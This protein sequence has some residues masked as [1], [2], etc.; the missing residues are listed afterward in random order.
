MEAAMSSQLQR[1]LTAETV[2]ASKLLHGSK[3]DEQIVRILCSASTI[4]GHGFS[5]VEAVP[6]S[7]ARLV[8]QRSTLAAVAPQPARNPPLVRPGVVIP[9]SWNFGRRPFWRLHGR[10]W[11]KD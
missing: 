4:G 5:S 3:I 6:R 1:V 7:P 2:R 10:L 11:I 8:P 9:S